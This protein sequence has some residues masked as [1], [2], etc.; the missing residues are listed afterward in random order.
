MQCTSNKK[1]HFCLMPPHSAP[2]S[3]SSAIDGLGITAR[4]FLTIRVL[5]FS[6]IFNQVN[7]KRRSLTYEYFLS[8]CKAELTPKAAG[9]DTTCRLQ[10]TILT[11]Q[12]GHEL[13]ISLSASS[14]L[15]SGHQI[16]RDL[17]PSLPLAP[18]SSCPSSATGAD[19]QAQLG[20]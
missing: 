18:C 16:S 19:A 8:E 3:K 6:Q 11:I 9:P 12:H 4:C 2:S 17:D 14:S 13:A 1:A 20:I 7:I 10:E 5:A 15:A